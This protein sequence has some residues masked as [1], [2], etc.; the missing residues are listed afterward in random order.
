[1]K[2]KNDTLRSC[3]DYKQLNK[4]MIRNKYPLPCINDLFYLLKR[5][6]VFS[7]INMR[8]GY[9]QLKVNESDIP[10]TTFMTRFGHY[11]FIVMTFVL[12]NVWVVF[13]DLMH[14]IFHP[15]LD[16][17]MILFINDIGV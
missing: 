10:K 3:V 1:M 8:S 7:K 4:V 17:F 14:Q 2:K 12:M 11:E 15:N 9:H 16:Q 6:F 5:S 13:V